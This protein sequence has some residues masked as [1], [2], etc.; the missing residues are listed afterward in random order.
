MQENR[1]SAIVCI[2]KVDVGINFYEH[3]AKSVETFLFTCLTLCTPMSMGLDIGNWFSAP[4]SSHIQHGFFACF[5]LCF[6]VDYSSTRYCCWHLAGF[7]STQCPTAEQLLEL[8]TFIA[9][10]AEFIQ[11]GFHVW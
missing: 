9:H 3:C 6:C 5:C 2:K 10:A 11:D 8:W 4:L 1:L 7:I